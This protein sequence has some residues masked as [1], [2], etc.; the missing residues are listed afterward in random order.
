MLLPPHQAGA[1]WAI[2]TCF[3]EGKPRLGLG[4]YE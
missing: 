1:R 4:D 3:R 2:E